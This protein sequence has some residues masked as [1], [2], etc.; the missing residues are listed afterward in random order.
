MTLQ[1]END[2]ASAWK[3]QKSLWLE[4]QAITALSAMACK[5]QRR[6]IEL[7]KKRQED[8]ATL[9][10]KSQPGLELQTAMCN[11]LKQQLSQKDLQIQ[12]LRTA[13]RVRGCIVA[14]LTKIQLLVAVVLLLMF[15][16]M[17][18]NKTCSFHGF[19]GH[20]GHAE[21]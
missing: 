9:A 1:Q 11:N 12:Q 10:K 17:Y 5:A 2:T 14:S 13:L 3:L 16:C 7:E 18:G 20:G 19:A 8:A 6:V 21:E 15:S 4:C